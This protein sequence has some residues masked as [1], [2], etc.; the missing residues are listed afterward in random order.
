VVT[1]H[2]SIRGTQKK[3]LLYVISNYMK[4]LIMEYFT[5]SSKLIQRQT[6]L[7]NVK[8]GYPFLQNFN[9]LEVGLYIFENTVINHPR[10]LISQFETLFRTYYI[11]LFR[12]HLN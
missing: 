11:L 2:A 8:K 10:I 3:K 4:L 5:C 12:V 6:Y 1:I 7:Y 9:D